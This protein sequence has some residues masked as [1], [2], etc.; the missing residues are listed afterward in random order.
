MAKSNRK[1]DYGSKAAW[2]WIAIYVAL[3]GLVYFFIYFLAFGSNSGKLYTPTATPTPA[4]F[5]N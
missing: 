2:Q 4:Q 1:G 5:Q 3:G